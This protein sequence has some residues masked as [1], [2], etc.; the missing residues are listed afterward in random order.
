MEAT[1]V[2]EFPECNRPAHC[3]GL[4]TGHHAQRSRG[5]ELAPLKQYKPRRN[6]ISDPRQRFESYIHKTETCWLW[7]GALTHDGYGV[8]RANNR[9]TGAHRFAYEFEHGPIPEGYQVD[10]TCRVRHCVNPE[11]LEA[12]PVGENTH[13]AWQARGQR[14]RVKSAPEE[15]EAMLAEIESLRGQLAQVRSLIERWSDQRVDMGTDWHGSPVTYV[16]ETRSGF[17][18]D[19]LRLALGESA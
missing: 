4:C 5:K 18:A 16:L 6:H 1:R 2:C 12:V 15:Q 8:F 3:R 17:Y 13:R 9:R 11:H 7:Q 19:Q 10:H 14:S